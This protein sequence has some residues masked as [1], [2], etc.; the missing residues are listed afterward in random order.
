[1]STT[2]V[3]NDT[4]TITRFL[5]RARL[6]SLIE[7]TLSE[8]EAIALHQETLRVGSGLMN[9]IATVEIAVRNSVGD[10]LAHH[11]GVDRWLT[12]T[13]VHFRWRAEDRKKIETALDSARRA[14]YSKLSQ[15]EKA[16]LDALAYPGG[17]PPSTSH[18]KRAKD[19]RKR[20]DVS[21]G[22]VIAELTMYFWKRL[23][24]PEYDQ[25]LW[26]ETLK[27]TFPCKRLRRADIAVQLEK[28]YQARNRLAHHEPVLHKRFEDT[29]A[30]IQFVVKH[31]NTASPKS[32]TPLATLVNVDLADVSRRAAALHER[33]K[34]YRRHTE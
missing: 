29:V 2:D 17:R 12:Q 9:V 34:A 24:G 30:A 7:L 3:S 18:L 27:R 4:L 20:I 28:V 32:D 8:T 23:Y 11:F 14:K 25:T 31:L 13:P 33:L 1:M 10:N 6:A 19:R 5:S 22:A 15:A 26:R 21:E 16:N